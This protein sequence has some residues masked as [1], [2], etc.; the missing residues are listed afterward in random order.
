M[1]NGFSSLM[2]DHGS[3][4][5]FPEQM[6]MSSISHISVFSRCSEFSSF[7]EFVYL[8]NINSSESGSTEIEAGEKN[9]YCF[10]PSF[11]VLFLCFGDSWPRPAANGQGTG[12]EMQTS[13]GLQLSARSQGN[14]ELL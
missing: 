11:E 12:R 3:Q 2:D 9:V 7:L 1:C 14:P 8:F 5:R 6:S 10:I 13:F 4:I